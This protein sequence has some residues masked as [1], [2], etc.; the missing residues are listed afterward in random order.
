MEL[1]NQVLKQAG[2]IPQ[3]R[4]FIQKEGGGTESTG[5]HTVKILRSGK[6]IVNI[7]NPR[8]GVLEPHIWVWFEEKG[9]EV[10]YSI[11][12]KN[13]QGG[14]H[15][16]IERFSTLEEGDIIILE[17]K[18]RANEIGQVTSFISVQK[19]TTDAEPTIEVPENGEILIGESLKSQIKDPWSIPEEEIPIIE[20]EEHGDF[21]EDN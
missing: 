20:E 8:T 21:S 11:P 1:F 4:L 3:L 2:V 17:G 15:Y 5:P 9:S 7:K 18:K 14:I 6:G 19:A 10:R 16:L 12:V 13:K